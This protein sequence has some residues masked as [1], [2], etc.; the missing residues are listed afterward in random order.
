M[1]NI[2]PLIFFII[3]LAI[4]AW[5][6]NRKAQAKKAPLSPRDAVSEDVEPRKPTVA[7]SIFERIKQELLEL[8]EDHS[9]MMPQPII[10]I[11]VVQEQTV[12]ETPTIRMQEGSSSIQNHRKESQ[13]AVEASLTLNVAKDHSSIDRLLDSY[14][15]I[16]QGIILSEVLGLPR[17]MQDKDKWFHSR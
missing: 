4:S 12:V 11:P 2:S 14:S 17:A 5:A 7:T 16:E 3:Y 8:D 15:K 1:E 6:K 10:P 9:P 13:A